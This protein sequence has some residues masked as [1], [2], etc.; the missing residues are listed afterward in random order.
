MFLSNCGKYIAISRRNDVGVDYDVTTTDGSE[1]WLSKRYVPTGWD[2]TDPR[3]V[4]AEFPHMVTGFSNFGRENFELTLT[5]HDVTQKVDHFK[6]NTI[7]GRLVIRFK[8]PIKR[9]AWKYKRPQL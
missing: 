2:D 3:Y 7:T 1:I 8:K 4:Y 9:L 6:G 5:D